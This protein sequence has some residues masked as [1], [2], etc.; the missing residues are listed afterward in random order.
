MDED[1]INDLKQFITS[2]ITQQTSDIT[3]RITVV[4]NKVDT[5]D[6]KIDNISK[7]VA[8]A[9]DTSNDVSDEQLKNH[10]IRIAGLEHK[11]A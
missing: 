9:L 2:V 7:S 10:E 11:L 5:V 3:D 6:S 1:T 8:E 4:E